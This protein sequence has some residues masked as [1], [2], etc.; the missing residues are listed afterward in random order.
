M[1]GERRKQVLGRRQL[2]GKR[3]LD[4][5][6][7]SFA[8]FFHT[9][10]TV[11]DVKI[12][13]GVN[14]FI[15]LFY[16]QP[17]TRCSYEENRGESYTF[18]NQSLYSHIFASLGSLDSFAYFTHCQDSQNPQNLSR[19]SRTDSLTIHISSKFLRLLVP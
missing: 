7:D 4:N 6:R 13:H 9:S 11:R 12:C 18:P 17:A 1:T 10:K 8:S 19:S 2:D 5:W 16:L 3:K 14:L 15:Y